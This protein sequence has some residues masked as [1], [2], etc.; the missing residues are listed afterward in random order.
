MNCCVTRR[1]SDFLLFH[2]MQA[3]DH[4]YLVVYSRSTIARNEARNE[5]L[6]DAGSGEQLCGLCH[7]PVEDPV[8]RY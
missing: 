3:V 6:A 1:I 4:P 8:V 7:D 2:E 5:A